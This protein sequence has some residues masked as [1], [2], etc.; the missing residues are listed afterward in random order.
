M[1]STS[2]TTVGGGIVSGGVLVK[3]ASHIAGEIGHTKVAWDASAR[4]C[5]C[6]LRGCIEAYLGGKN[7]ARRAREEVGAGASPQTLAFAGGLS[8]RGE[9]PGNPLEGHGGRPA[10]TAT[11]LM[12]GRLSGLGLSS[13]VTL[14]TVGGTL[15]V[16]GNEVVQSHR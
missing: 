10:K 6:G 12:A 14:F 16:A 9:Q 13:S 8:R 11:F 4:P 5:G 1:F 7:L 2:S 3:G 15:G